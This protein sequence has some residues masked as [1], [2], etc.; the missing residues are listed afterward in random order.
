[1]LLLV[2][3]L[4]ILIAAADAGCSTQDVAWW[5]HGGGFEYMHISVLMPCLMEGVG[6]ELPLDRAVAYCVARG[7]PL[8]IPCA[9]CFVAYQVCIAEQCASSCVLGIENIVCDDCLQSNCS[10]DFAACTD[11]DITS[12]N[13]CPEC[14]SVT[15]KLPS[16][17]CASESDTPMLVV[18]SLTS[19]LSCSLI[20]FA[21]F[22][23]FRKK[24]DLQV[25]Q[26]VL[27]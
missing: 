25:A 9:D 23:C 2:S 13:K 24:H 22:V 1:M 26:P 7:T 6:S 19:A 5:E 11:Y 15:W 16:S 8:T 27:T 21:L 18:V 3:I 14:S 4:T 12:V 20:C 10:A 17:D